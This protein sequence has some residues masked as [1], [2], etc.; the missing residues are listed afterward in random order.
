MSCLGRL[1][2]TERAMVD[3][4]LYVI[5]HIYKVYM[6]YENVGENFCSGGN[7]RVYGSICLCVLVKGKLINILLPSV[8]EN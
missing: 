4:L 2:V 5:I 3:P 1:Q 6:S 7:S 8:M